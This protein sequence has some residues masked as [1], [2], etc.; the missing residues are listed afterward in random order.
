MK[1]LIAGHRGQLGRDVM[2][3]L[4]RTH[5]VLGADLPEM[6]LLDEGRARQWVLAHRPHAIV[7]CIAYTRVD[8]AEK[9]DEREPCRRLNAQLPR[10]LAEVA[11]EAGAHFVHISTDYVFDGQRTPPQPY[12]ETDATGPLSWYG[13]T[14]LVGEQS[15]QSIGGRWAILR[16]SWLY[17][18][19]GKNFP[20]AILGR[21]IREPSKPL[22]VVN[23]QFGSPTWSFR[24]AQ[25][26]LAVLESDAAG[27]YHATSEG[28]CSW[29]D[30][31]QTLLECAGLNQSVVPC[32]TSAYPTPARRP[33]NSIL[34]NAALKKAGLN[35]FV[36]W[37]TDVVEFMHRFG[38]ELMREI[39]TEI[40]R[41]LE[42]A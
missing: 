7:N 41:T 27:L 15:V 37:R 32:P 38:A 29:Y 11:H 4:G 42:R 2:G 14:K 9:Q 19:N 8:D 23:D 36:D 31:A 40:A 18:R 33:A 17:G 22:R 10:L 21:A 6:N 35:Q 20:K 30:F 1:I 12:V 16:T 28:Y 39:R 5:D 26:I 24:L 13:Q 25:Q 3:V 34:E